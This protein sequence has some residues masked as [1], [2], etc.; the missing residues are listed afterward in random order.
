MVSKMISEM[1]LEF[2][3]L[4]GVRFYRKRRGTE[5]VQNITKKMKRNSSPD[6]GTEKSC[7]SLNV[8]IAKYSSEIIEPTKLRIKIIKPESKEENAFANCRKRSEDYGRNIS[9]KDVFKVASK[10]NKKFL[11]VDGKTFSRQSVEFTSEKENGLADGGK[12]SESSHRNKGLKDG[13]K[14][15]TKSR[16][17][18]AG[19]RGV[20]RVSCKAKKPSSN[21]RKA[22]LN[23]RARIAKRIGLS[24]EQREA[25]IIPSRKI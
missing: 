2:E 20:K 16:E 14:I 7:P 17:T 13:L 23:S 8:R 15:A 6:R 1:N 12:R 4:H 25:F 21:S 5:F 11:S 10:S 3:T 19:S 22:A 9:A 18:F 24:R